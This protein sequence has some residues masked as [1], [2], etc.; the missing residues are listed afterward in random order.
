MQTNVHLLIV[1]PQNDFCDLPDAL[2]P[3]VFG[4]RQVP[5]LG[6]PGA[7]EDMRKLAAFIGNMGKRL[8][9][10]TVTLD[11][12]PYIAIERTTF[13]RDRDGR[14][15]APFTVISADSVAAGD[16]QP[17]A[18]PA[19]VLSQLRKLEARGRHQLVV[20]PVHC[21]IGTWGHNIH[22]DVTTALNAW[23]LQTRRP[24]RKVLKGEYP[25]SEHY[26]VFEAETPMA[27]VPSTHFNTRLARELIQD[28]D[29]LVVA[30]EASSHCVAASVEQLLDAMNPQ[31]LPRIVLLTDCMSPVS[32][33]E[34]VE[35]AFFARAE[36]AGVEM[37]TTEELAE[38]L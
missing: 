36:A 34:E 7:H 12:H 38:K 32:G 17:I 16:Y 22:A 14:H 11:S 35:Q 5:A 28:V 27:E 26:G 8:G 31:D 25:F 6:V 4:E 20:W 1:D 15:V 37:C 9:E 21:V 2:L 33:F 3:V 23:E 18:E 13:W 19:L 10:V 24:V 30:G 29:V